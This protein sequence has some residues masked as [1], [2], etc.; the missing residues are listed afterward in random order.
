MQNI[1]EILKNPPPGVDLTLVGG[2]ALIYWTLSYSER[3]PD[4]FPDSVIS[5]TFDI[6][7]V[8][9]LKESC[10]KCVE[11]WGGKLNEPGY[12]DA[13]P[14]MGV[15]LIETDEGP[16][17]IDLLPDLLRIPK[18]EIPKLRDPIGDHEAYDDMYVLSEWGTLLNRVHNTVGMK[19]Y[20]R[21]EAL[22]Q[23]DNAIAIF[24]AY[25]RWLLDEGE[26]SEAQSRISG[27]VKLA[28]DSRTGIFLFIELGVDL[29]SPIPRGHRQFE[30]AFREHVL[31]KLIAQVRAKRE[32]LLADKYRRETERNLTAGM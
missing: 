24:S 8:V 31:D 30:P 13:T 23:L 6:D 14:E 19:R 20:R 21:P 18:Q 27:L 5:S 4:L 26:V 29:L 32:R 1:E 11:H 22:T 16:I 10:K 28:L 7:F 9:Q 17:R 12:S 15:I 3:Y 25:I 2:Q